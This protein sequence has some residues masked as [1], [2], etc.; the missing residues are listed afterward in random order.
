MLLVVL[1]ILW[2]QGPEGYYLKLLGFLVF[3]ITSY[4]KMKTEE[5]IIKIGDT[6]SIIS[7]PNKMFIKLL[8]MCFYYSV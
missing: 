7:R 8:V 6:N 4:V 1:A 3:V 5:R 2:F